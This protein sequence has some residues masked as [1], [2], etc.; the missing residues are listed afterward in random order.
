MEKLGEV[1]LYFIQR[2][3]RLAAPTCR[4]PSASRLA[5]LLG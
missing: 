4:S 5:C 2:A 1:R 3:L